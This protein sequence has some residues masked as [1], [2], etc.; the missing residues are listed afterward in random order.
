M[1]KK[2]WAAAGLLAA[3]V[4]MGSMGESEAAGNGYVNM[5]AVLAS[6]AEFQQAGK[7]VAAEQQKL[8]KEYSDQSQGMSD[9]DKAALQQKLNQ[10][11]NDLQ[12]QVLAPIQKKIGLAVQ[13][14][15]E[16]RNI[17]FVVA[18]GAVLYGGTDLTEDV[19]S[20]MKNR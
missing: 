9:Q 1:N 3:A 2:K 17:D 8:Q 12:N 10:Q 18:S 11:L 7:T 6:S 4:M 15:A 19:K 20:S 14:A 13:A 5:N 16:K